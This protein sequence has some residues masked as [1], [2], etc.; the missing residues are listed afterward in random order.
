[1]GQSTKL[2][3]PGP[4]HTGRPHGHV[5]LEKLEHNSHGYSTRSCHSNRLEHGRVTRACLCRAQVKSNLERATFE[6][7]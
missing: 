6:G 7:V 1:M 5:N 4:P 3:R 2:T